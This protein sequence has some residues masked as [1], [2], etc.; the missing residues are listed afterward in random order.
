MKINIGNTNSPSNKLVKNFTIS[1]SLNG[2]FRNESEIVNPT[3]LIETNQNI[4]NYNY[5]QIPDFNRYYYI[6]SLKVIRSN[7]YEIKAHCDVLNSFKNEI[8]KN[9]AIVLRQ[10]N[11]FNLLLNDNVFKC[12]QNPRI[13]YKKF[14]NSMGEYCFILT[15]A[16]GY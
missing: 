2:N 16:G 15:V 10:E 11:N 12:K 7:L 5:L 3:I 6:T 9:K 8:N 14:P 13:Y 1:L 4:S